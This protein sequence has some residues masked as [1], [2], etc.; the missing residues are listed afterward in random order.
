MI[1]SAVIAGYDYNTASQTL[2]IHYQTGNIHRYHNVPEK[3]YLAMRS[4]I[5]KGYFLN[6]EI[7]GR[8]DYD[9]I[10]PKSA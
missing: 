5:Y 9:D 3:V 6:R 7:N 1:Q 10:T 2:T 8:Y 4:I